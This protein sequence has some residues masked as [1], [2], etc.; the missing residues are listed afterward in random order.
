MSKIILDYPM[1]FFFSGDK[2]GFLGVN[3]FVMIGGT[4]A[5]ERWIRGQGE[6]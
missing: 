3:V 6:W 5:I 1:P 2:N 4:L